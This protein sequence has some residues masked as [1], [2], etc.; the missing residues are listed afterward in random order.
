MTG[1]RIGMLVVRGPAPQPPRRSYRG[2]WWLCDC[3]CGGQKV[4]PGCFLRAGDVTNC[5]CVKR[6]RARTLVRFRWATRAVPEPAE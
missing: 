1:R 3:D 2:A 5:G 4:A 6:E